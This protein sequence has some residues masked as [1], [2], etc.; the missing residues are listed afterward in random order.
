MESGKLNL[1][2]IILGRDHAAALV[3][4]GRGLRLRA[5]TDRQLA[6]VA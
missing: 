1:E 2:K 5:Q 6:T 4:L 3:I